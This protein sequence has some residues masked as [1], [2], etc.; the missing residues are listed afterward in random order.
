MIFKPGDYDVPE[1]PFLLQRPGDSTFTTV[2]S[3]PF[4]FSVL[5]PEIDKEQDIKDIKSIWKIPYTFQ[6]IL[7]YAGSFLGLIILIAAILLILYFRKKRTAD[8]VFS[9]KPKHSLPPHVEAF[10][11]LEKLRLSQMW[12][13]GLVKAYYTELTDIL[14]V[15]IERQLH[16]P[17][18]EMTSDELIDAINGSSIEENKELLL[19]ILNSVLTTADLVK[20]AKSNP[21]P[22]E[23]DKCFK[24]VKQFVELTKPKEEVKS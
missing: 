9:F 23:H 14:R 10:E 6:E 4:S 7:P 12:Q 22:D 21:L 2:F 19:K 20:F 1:L 16:I 15:Y 3:D 18:V 5:A 13:T 11:R 24:E 17:A 8:G